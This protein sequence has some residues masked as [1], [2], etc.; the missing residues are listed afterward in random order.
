MWQKR[1]L[2]KQPYYL[3]LKGRE[4]FGFAGLWETW[5]SPEG[6][7]IRSCTIITVDSNELL[8][9]IHDRMPLILTQ[10]A[11]AIWLDPAIQEPIRLLPLP[12]PYP[13]EA[14]EAYPVS[15]LVNRPD[16][17]SGECIE[18]LRNLDNDR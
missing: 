16:H 10:G 11:E 7:E 12:R 17:D 6:E 9:P 13:A 15:Q 1:T 18:P 4:P 2:G 3:A 5:M 14:M 8:R